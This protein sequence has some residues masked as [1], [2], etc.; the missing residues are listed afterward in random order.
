MAVIRL[1]MSR[2]STIMYVQ[3]QYDSYENYM[4]LNM[5]TKALDSLIK[6]SEQI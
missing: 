2:A 4:K 5:K 1:F 3:K 6:G